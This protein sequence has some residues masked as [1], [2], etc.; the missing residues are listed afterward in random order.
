M[1]LNLPRKQI[2]ITSKIAPTQ[3][4]YDQAKQACLTIIEKLNCGYLDLLLIH[5]PGVSKLKVDDPKNA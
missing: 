4:G 1:K 2:Y 3:Q 5:W